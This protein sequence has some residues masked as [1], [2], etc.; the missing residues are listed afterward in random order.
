MP[1]RAAIDAILLVLHT[2]GQWN[3]LN[4][5]GICSLRTAHRRFPEWQRAGVAHEFRCQGL[6]ADDEVVGIDWAWR[7]A[8]SAMTTA[9]APG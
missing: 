5:T 9:P 8:C 7:A 2:G 1:N 4:T 3:A 6:L